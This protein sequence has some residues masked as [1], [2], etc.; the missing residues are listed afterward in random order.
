MFTSPTVSEIIAAHRTLAVAAAAEAIFMG[1]DASIPDPDF[2]ESR[3]RT[4][5]HHAIAV[6]GL[7]EWIAARPERDTPLVVR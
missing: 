2:A 5:F 1:R 4:A 7:S 3:A 6:H